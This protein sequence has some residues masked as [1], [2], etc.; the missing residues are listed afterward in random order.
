MD[1]IIVK[2]SNVI[3]F[4]DKEFSTRGNIDLVLHYALSKFRNCNI[5]LD[6]FT[7]DCFKSKTELS[8]AIF[9][10]RCV[11]EKL[12][13]TQF[14]ECKEI[15]KKVNFYNYEIKIRNHLQKLNIP[16]YLINRFFNYFNK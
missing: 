5:E 2:N 16:F 11:K 4:R 10:Y 14:K 7:N 3:I 1:K 8:K 15:Y 9:E 13:Y 6:I 12:K